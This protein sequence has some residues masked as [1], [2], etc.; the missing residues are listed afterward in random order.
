MFVEGQAV[1]VD[2]RSTLMKSTS[3]G[4]YELANALD[5][6]AHLSGDAAEIASLD[7][8]RTLLTSLP[9]GSTVKAFEGAM[10]LAV[11]AGEPWQKPV[12]R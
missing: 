5:R 7:A 6:Q 9:L 1:K 11:D 3:R 4:R 10:R 12:R 8:A 2:N